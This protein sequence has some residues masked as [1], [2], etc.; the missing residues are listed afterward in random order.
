MKSAKFNLVAWYIFRGDAAEISVAKFHFMKPTPKCTN[1][2]LVNLTKLKIL[3][4]LQRG[5]GVAEGA[6][7]GM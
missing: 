6:E 4:D 5:F 3:A 1:Q 7:K 2:D